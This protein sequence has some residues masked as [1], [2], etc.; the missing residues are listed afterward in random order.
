MA[1]C[2]VLVLR[3]NNNVVLLITYYHVIYTIMIILLVRFIAGLVLTISGGICQV[4]TGET[5]SIPTGRP[6]GHVPGCYSLS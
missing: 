6:R 3:T 2:F 1:R 5:Q 4:A